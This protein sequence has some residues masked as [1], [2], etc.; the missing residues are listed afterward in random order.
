MGLRSV[1]AGWAILCATIAL[2]EQ[3]VPFSHKQHVAMAI[4]C[5]DCHPGADKRAVAGIPSVQKCMLCHAKLGTGKPGVKLVIDYSKSGREIPWK[6][7]YGFDPDALVKFRHAPHIQAKIDCVSCHGDMA[8]A[9]VAEP[10]VKHNMGTCL[11]CHR[12]RK[13]AQDCTACHY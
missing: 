8:Q 1:A 2:A 3:P 6:R 7:V 5:L 13:A 11:T 9:T 10:L 12:Q 4:E